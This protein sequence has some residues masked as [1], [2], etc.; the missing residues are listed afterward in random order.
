MLDVRWRTKGYCPKKTP[1]CVKKARKVLGF[2]HKE[3]AKENGWNKN[4]CEMEYSKCIWRKENPQYNQNPGCGAVSQSVQGLLFNDKCK[5][6]EDY[7][8]GPF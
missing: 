3:K 7:K 4:N 8:A 2:E 1:C 5:G 6:K